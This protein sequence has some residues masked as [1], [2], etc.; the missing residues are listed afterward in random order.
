M[1]ILGLVAQI[2]NWLQNLWDVRVVH[3]YTDQKEKRVVHVYCEEG[4]GFLRRVGT[5]VGYSSS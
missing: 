2:R 3:I 1:F 5:L 4:S